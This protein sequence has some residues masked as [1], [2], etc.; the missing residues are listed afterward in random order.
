MAGCL[1]AGNGDGPPGAAG[2]GGALRLGGSQG[3]SGGARRAASLT[4]ARGPREMARIRS[5]DDGLGTP[6][7]RGDAAA[8]SFEAV[9]WLGPARQGT[10]GSDRDSA[11]AGRGGAPSDDDGALAHPS[12]PPV[13]TVAGSHRGER[14]VA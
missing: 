2:G 8:H 11:G 3:R 12:T 9:R 1:R 7:L 10:G 6:R 5:H 14:V 13:I 4:L